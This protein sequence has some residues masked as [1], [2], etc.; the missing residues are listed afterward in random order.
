M[1]AGGALSRLAGT[2]KDSAKN[3]WKVTNVIY[4]I[5]KFSVMNFK[6]FTIG[7]SSITLLRLLPFLPPVIIGVHILFSSFW[8]KRVLFFHAS[9]RR[10]FI[11]GLYSQWTGLIILLILA[12]VI[13]T[14]L[15]DEVAN[16]F[17][18]SMPLLNV[19]VQK[20]LGWR[21]S[22]AASTFAICSAISFFTAY[23]ILRI[24]TDKDHENLTNE[25]KEWRE[26]VDSKKKCTYYNAFG[27]K[28]EW[29][30][31]IK[32]K[33][34]RI[35]GWN[36]IL[37]IILCLIACGFG[38]VANLY[39]KIDMYREPKGAFGRTLDK[40]LTKVTVYEDDMR[41]VRE[42]GEKDCLPFATFQDVLKENMDRRANILMNPINHFFN[43]T[44]EIMKPL[45]DIVS[46]TRRQLIADI[47]DELFGEEA[48][49]NIKDFKKL[50]LRYLGLLL[51]IPRVLNLLVLVFGS[52]SMCY[53]TCQMS[54]IPAIEPRKIV[55]FFGSVC[56]FSL[57]Y[58]L[59]TQMAVFNILS[60]IGV[61]FYR[62]S[63]RLG[64]G[65]LYDVAA[66]AIMVSV[67]IG[68]RNQY[69]FAIPQRKVTVSYSVPGV[70]DVGP[71]PPNRIL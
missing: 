48:L 61:P 16:A 66:E 17:N 70:S 3:L 71:N 8:P 35:G 21:L 19:H 52:L 23:I 60:D 28:I 57:V 15:V 34:E 49:Q 54:I 1:K 5:G 40:I 32:Y 47:G 67:W 68:M 22:I 62:I 6:T 63:V 58:V 24:K 41:R 25:E 42:Y 7:G 69:F 46:R 30:N 56:V 14:A 59:G 38:V 13:N 10:K 27:P 12:L 65:F 20:K 26:F 64:L 51:I 33:K 45:K 43:K 37:P 39:P 55:N 44:E 53:A 18:E 50:D 11:D 9:Q 4:K 36:W 29:K 31:Q 2:L